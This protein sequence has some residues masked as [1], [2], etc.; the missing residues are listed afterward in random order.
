M[1]VGAC[2]SSACATASV[3][4]ASLADRFVVT[5]AP[6]MSLDA[7]AAT[8]PDG[9]V[10]AADSFV[11]ATAP[12]SPPAAIAM[13]PTLEE[14]SPVLRA[15]LAALA[16][17]PTAQAHLDVATAY[18]SLHVHDRAFDYL[19][20]GLSRYHLDPALHDAVARLWRDWGMPDRAL[21][22]A[23]LAVRHAPGWAPAF[24][25]LGTVL[26]VLEAREDA[27]DAFTRAFELAPESGWA[28]T[29]YCR[30]T[31]AVGRA[32]PFRCDGVEAATPGVR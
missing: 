11:S 25:T 26:W 30:A 12:A 6:A 24:T 23:H 21:R 15:R 22:H 9:D 32:R 5:G 3:G 19:E 2:A 17:T 18:R 10:V 27:V 31:V 29:N 13:A 7:G 1:L 28:R 16:A 20:L 8:R 14:T 4:P